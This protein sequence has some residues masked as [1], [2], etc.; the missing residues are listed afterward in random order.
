MATTQDVS[1]GQFLKYNGELVQ[2]LELQH[3]TPGNLRAFYQGK[4]RN[5]KNGKLLENRF[6]SGEEVEIVRVEYK[7]MQ[8]SYRDGENLVCMDPETFDQVYVPEVYFGDSIK[9]LKEE[10][11]VTVT[12]YEDQPILAAPPTFVELD[13][14]YCEPAVRG[15]TSTNALKQATVETGATVMV[16][17]FV[18]DG[19]KIKIDTRT[20]DYVERVKA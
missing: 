13:I 15:D 4:M 16:P 7:P 20:G 17:M 11:T 18:N 2:V 10:M 3:R 1:I 9:F 6:R 12:F 5:I 8:F 19:E 14:T